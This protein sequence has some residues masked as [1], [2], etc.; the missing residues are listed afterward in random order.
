[1]LRKYKELK[2]K[3]G[4]YVYFINEK[5]EG[6]DGNFETEISNESFS[7]FNNTTGRSEVVNIT[8]LQDLRKPKI[9]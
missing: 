8:N 4:D 3:F 2:L 7:F 9:Q 1:M 6:I 5:G